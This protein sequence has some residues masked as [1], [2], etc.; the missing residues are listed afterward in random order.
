MTQELFFVK[1]MDGFNHISTNFIV[2]LVYRFLI[3]MITETHNIQ[4]SKVNNLFLLN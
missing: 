4:K 3:T 1:L 2:M